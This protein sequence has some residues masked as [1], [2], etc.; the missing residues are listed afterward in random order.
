MVSPTF[1]NLNL[2]LAIK[3]SL[4][5]H[6][7]LPVFFFSECI[8]LLRL[9]CKEYNQSNFDIDNLV[10]SMCRVFSCVVGRGC[11]H[12]PDK[13]LLAFALLHFVL[14]GQICLLLQ[15]SVDFLLSILVPY[16]EKD[17]FFGCLF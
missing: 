14:Q 17:I 16:N 15:V 9:G 3:N 6:S 10:M 1:F 12:S 8:E 2:N 5:E 4:S 7:Q 11:L 13:A